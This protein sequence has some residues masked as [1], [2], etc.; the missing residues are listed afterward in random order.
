[1]EQEKASPGRPG[2]SEEVN[3]KIAERLKLGDDPKTISFEEGIGLTKV[4][5]IRRQ[6]VL[7]TSF[8]AQSP[9]GGTK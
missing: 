2:H 9:L 3:E 6:L 5:E 8:A 4:Y 1:M 7:L